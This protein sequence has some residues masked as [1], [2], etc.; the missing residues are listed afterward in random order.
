MQSGSNDNM[1]EAIKFG[2]IMF[3]LCIISFIIFTVIF[4][5]KFPQLV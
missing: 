3:G 4:S 2:A 1:A 5:I